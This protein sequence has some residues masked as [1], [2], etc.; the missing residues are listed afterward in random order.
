MCK[1]EDSIQLCIQREAML[2]QEGL[3]VTEPCI[4]RAP[5]PYRVGAL[6]G[7][8]RWRGKLGLEQAALRIQGSPNPSGWSFPWALTS[9]TYCPS[10]GWSLRQLCMKRGTWPSTRQPSW[11]GSKLC[12]AHILLS[13]PH[14]WAEAQKQRPCLQD[15][16]QGSISLLTI[17]PW[18]QSTHLQGAGDAGL[19]RSSGPL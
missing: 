14:S 18:A 16:A 8:T 12:R 15:G 5:A 13:L 7:R 6:V 19:A 4:L 10:F 11:L 1:S 17:A 3:E 2:E 9:G